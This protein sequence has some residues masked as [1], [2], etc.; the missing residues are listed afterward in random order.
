MDRRGNRYAGVFGPASAPARSPT[1]SAQG[2]KQRFAIEVP[3]AAITAELPLAALLDQLVASI[4]GAVADTRRADA[5][6]VA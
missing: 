2:I 3:L 5:R 6:G 1:A 4:A